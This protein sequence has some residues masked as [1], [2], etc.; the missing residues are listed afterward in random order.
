MIKNPLFLAL[1]LIFCQEAFSQTNV[2]LKNSHTEYLIESPEKLYITENYEIVIHNQAGGRYSVIGDYI[3]QFKKIKNIK[4]EVFDQ[5]GDRVKK[6]R[7]SDAIEYNF[8]SSYE[9]NDSKIVILNPDYA[10]YPFTVKVELESEF[11]GF[12]ALPEWDPQHAYNMKV[13]QASLR[14]IYPEGQEIKLFEHNISKKQEAINE[15]QIVVDYEVKDL[16]IVSENVNI[17]KFV[18]ITPLVKMS[19]LHFELDGERGSFE[20][21][22]TFG[23][24]FLQ[25]NEGRDSLLSDTKNFLDNLKGS[26]TE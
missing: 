2:T 15:G 12:M 1:I 10:N 20:S 13:E 19:P 24:W 3:D 16:D 14:L 26:D 9:I 21:W 7:K 22:N 5:Y 6:L 18:E 17:K 11:D 23:E 25:L 8:S 4:V